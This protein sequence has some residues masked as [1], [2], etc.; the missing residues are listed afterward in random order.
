MEGRVAGCLLAG[1]CTG[2]VLD[3]A[4]YFTC[5][6]L[7][8]KTE[9]VT[10]VAIGAWRLL[11]A[12]YIVSAL[13]CIRIRRCRGTEPGTCTS[14]EEAGNNRA[15]RTVHEFVRAAF[16]LGMFISPTMLIYVLLTRW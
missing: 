11:V 13:P 10:I 8:P 1:I 7:L 3:T 9:Y 14:E 2:A 16:L 5:R 6:K 4:I 12:M 15:D